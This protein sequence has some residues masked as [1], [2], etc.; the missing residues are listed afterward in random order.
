MK[1]AIAASASATVAATTTPLPAARPSAL[2]TIGAPRR[3]TK[4]RAATGVLEPL[5][6]RG[7]DAGGVAHRSL[8]KVLLPSSRAAAADGPQQAMPAGP[9]ASA[10]P[11]TSGASGPGTT[12]STALLAREVDQRGDVHRADRHV[13]APPARCRGCPARTRV[14]SAAGWPRAPSTARARARPI[15]PPAPACASLSASFNRCRL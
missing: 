13:L 14:W 6:A 10:R 7:R 1:S 12:R 2:T 9:I 5:P 4:S 15:R 8:A 3:R 11:A